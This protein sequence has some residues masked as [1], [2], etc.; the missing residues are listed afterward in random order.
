M[1]TCH[2]GAGASLAAVRF[3]V[4]VDTTMGFTPL[5][6][7]V[8]ATRAG[9]VDPGLVLWL[10]EHVGMPPAELASTLE[11][12][13]GLLGLAGNADMRA[14]LEAEG[15][16]DE[17]ASLA[18]G[19]YLHRLRAE[20]AAMTAAM[21][22]LDT[23]V[24][25]G[26]VGE[27]APSIR[28]RAAAGLGFLGIDVDEAANAAAQPDAEIT[29]AGADVRALVIEAR[30]DRQIAGLVVQLLRRGDDR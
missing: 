2:L 14:V 20:I 25:T 13:S 19:V 26:G 7:L 28:L 4:S 17:A 3:G 30:E 16:G 5:E 12:R 18:I 15:R 10:E 23:L 6:G 29:A 24:F 22:G 1:V 8:M 27:R 21:G 11:H 9:S